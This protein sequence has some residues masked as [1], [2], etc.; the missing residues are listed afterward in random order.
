MD[1]A[2]GV[3]QVFDDRRQRRLRRQAVV[4]RHED[5]AGAE[6]HVLDSSRDCRP[7]AVNQRPSVDPDR[8]GPLGA[9]VRTQNIELDS[10]LPRLLVSKCLGSCR[11]LGDAGK[12]RPG[13]R[14][15]GQPQEFP[16][17]DIAALDG[18]H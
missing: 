11:A 2:K 5:I 3:F 9:V 7:M 16:A 10:E 15:H 13:A 14:A 1:P 17:F 8:H 6:H 12:D 4:D 18:G